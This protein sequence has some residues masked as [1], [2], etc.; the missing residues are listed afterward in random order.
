MGSFGIKIRRTTNMNLKELKK[1]IPW[2]IKLGIKIMLSWIPNK[3]VFFRPFGIIYKLGDMMKPEYSL[4]VFISHLKGSNFDTKNN[5]ILEIGP[6]DSI[7]TGI[8][9]WSMGAKKS[10]L[11][12]NGNY[13]TKDI[14]KYKKLIKILKN[15]GYEK[16]K[17][18]E[19]CTNFDELLKVANIIYLNKG[20]NS[21]RK[22]ESN[23]IDF[24]F[25]QNVLEHIF[26]N[27][28]S[29]FIS[30]LY[31]VQKLG[32]LS[33]HQVDLKDHL[34]KSL[35]SLRFPIAIWESNLFKRAGFYT[36]RLRCYQLKK[37]FQMSGFNILKIQLNKWKQ[38]PV[39]RRWF[40]K[41][42]KN[43]VEEELLIKEMY[44]LCE[45]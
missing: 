40:F 20:L 27:E 30:E 43:I 5:V 14:K 15:S 17:K 11:I 39:K 24:C 22:I 4:Q 12:D 42:F 33:S 28:F 36:N 45:K 2:Y 10:I 37:I 41:D 16:A 9:A 35:N 3:E 13:A 38:I 1:L 21:L 6:G 23:S 29:A 44:I 19:E 8:I 25:S 31:R 26:L 7:S 32:G 34:G 18:L